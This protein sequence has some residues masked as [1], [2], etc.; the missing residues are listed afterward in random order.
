MNVFRLIG[1]GFRKIYSSNN[2]AIKHVWLLVLIGIVPVV[3]LYSLNFTNVVAAKNIRFLTALVISI[4]LCGYNLELVH[5]SFTEKDILPELGFNHFGLFFKALPLILT[6]TFYIITVSIVA[7]L[8]MASKISL[9]IGLLL[10]L[11]LVFV[12]SFLQFVFVEFSKNYDAKGLYGILQPFKYVKTFGYLLL[13]GLLF[14][15]IYIILSSIPA[16]IFGFVAGLLTGEDS[17]LVFYGGGFIGGYFGF[18]VGMVWNYCLVQ[19]YKEKFEPMTAI[20]I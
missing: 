15:P 7:G 16:F 6:W 4:Y 17:N 18:I 9:I 10:I 11:V 2:I 3:F 12:S 20:R 5:N 13:L 1:D 14:I 19:V 8:L